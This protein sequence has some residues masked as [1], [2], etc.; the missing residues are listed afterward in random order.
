AVVADS[1]RMALAEKV[2]VRPD[3]EISAKGAKSRHSVRVEVTLNDG[4]L[5]ERAVETPRGSEPNFASE[6]QIVAKFEKL[7]SRALKREQIA[8]LRDAVLAVEKLKDASRIAK[9]LTSKR[10]K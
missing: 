8:R 1:R 10:A 7:A 9:L 2:E 5:L 4:S 3:P 6:A